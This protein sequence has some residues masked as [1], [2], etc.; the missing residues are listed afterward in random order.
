ML[1]VNGVQMSH[2]HTKQSL[3]LRVRG[4]LLLI[5]LLM[6][7]LSSAQIVDDSTELVYGPE[8]TSFIT[9]SRILNN[10]DAY[11]GVD[12]SIY[13]FERQSFYDRSGRAYQDLGNFGTANTPIF[14][15][16][17]TSIGRSS[18]FNAYRSYAYNPEDIA[19]YDTKSPFIDLFVYLGGGN[20]NI[21]DL[22]FSRNVNANWNLGF[23]LRK[24]TSNKQLAP[25]SQV[26][27]QSVGSSFAGYTYYQHPKLPYRV[28]ANYTSM[29][30]K[31][32]EVGGARP[33]ADSLRI[34]YFLFDNA[35]VRLENAQAIVKY[36]RWN[37]YHDYQIANQFQLYHSLDQYKEINTFEDIV[38]GTAADGYDTYRDFYNAFLIDPDSTNERTVFRSF[39]NEVGIKGNLSSVF[40][41]LYG[42][43]RSINWR[44]QY[45][46]PDEA[47]FEKYLGGYVRFNWKEKFAV[48]GSAEYLIGGDYRIGGS[49]S[50]DLLKVKYTSSKY[51]VPFIYSDYFGNHHEWHNDFSSVFANHLEGQLNLKL[52]SLE[53]NPKVRLTTYTNFLYFDETIRPTQSS[54]ALL[55]SSFGG[56]LNVRLYNQKGEGWHLENDLMATTVSG[57]AASA[58]RVPD[59]FYNGRYYWRG[60]WF[61][62]LVPVEFGIDAHARSA[63]FANAYAP[64]IQQFYV[65]N[66]LEI[67]GYV[68]A[69]LFVNMQVDKFRFAVKWTHMNQPQDDGYFA[70]PYYPGQRKVIDIIIKWMFFD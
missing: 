52:K 48:D 27:R 17:P 31:V 24:I 37:I 46:D 2:I 38:G 41:R 20:R 36:T 45:F 33:T 63:Y 32:V 53:L 60:K 67:F 12:T 57:E 18:G 49:L 43:V 19:Y 70:T 64:E 6:A 56:E 11:E 61:K 13:L 26:D 62:D 29:N 55:I 9:G 15:T 54:D 44:Y 7:L 5:T 16:P 25:T 42:K 34:D 3:N 69:D 8:T 65:Q 66:D 59:L 22:G 58:V 40:Y 21:V 10:I 39:S 28:T 23:D 68:A 50:S 14:F 51:R 47:A 4:F 1:F 30:H 35:L